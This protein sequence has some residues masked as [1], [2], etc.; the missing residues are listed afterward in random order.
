VPEAQD[1]VDD[2]AVHMHRFVQDAAL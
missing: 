1:I 2:L